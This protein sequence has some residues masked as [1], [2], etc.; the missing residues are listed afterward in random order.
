MA[1][2]GANLLHFGIIF[3]GHKLPLFHY[4]SSVPFSH[5]GSFSTGSRMP[6]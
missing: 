3:H 1:A 2:F 4:K 5:A 6:T